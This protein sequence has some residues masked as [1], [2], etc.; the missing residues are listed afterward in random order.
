MRRNR[1]AAWIAAMALGLAPALANAQQTES[2]TLATA[3]LSLFNYLPISLAERSG[4]FK[5]QG[6]KVE[7]SD[8]AGGQKSIEALVGGSIE[9][10]VAS[11]DN[12][13]ERPDRR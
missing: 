5:E 1:C 10:A 7:I 9:L 6:L 3:G 12:A 4:A 13:I 11:F 8:F 2:V